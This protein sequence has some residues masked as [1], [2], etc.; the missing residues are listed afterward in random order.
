MR[1]APSLSPFMDRMTTL[2]CAD[3]MQPSMSRMK[4][5]RW[6]VGDTSPSC[7]RPVIMPS[8]TAGMMRNRAQRMDSNALVCR[9]RC[10]PA[11][12]ASQEDATS[13]AAPPRAALLAKDPASTSTT[14]GRYPEPM[15]RIASVRGEKGAVGPRKSVESSGTEAIVRP[16]MQP[17]M[18][19]DSMR[20]PQGDAYQ[21][22]KAF[23]GLFFSPASASATACGF[24]AL[25]GSGVAAM[26]DAKVQKA[27]LQPSR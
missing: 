14:Q 2:F 20:L 5:S 10:M 9:A 26:A 21:S 11:T 17:I 3:G 25:F 16:L 4:R 6:L 22:V 19:G 15:V 12:F 8:A 18:G 24:A 13:P 23:R 27:G 7:V 1:P